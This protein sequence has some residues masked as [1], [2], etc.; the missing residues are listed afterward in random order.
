MPA[1]GPEQV[2]QV[3]PH[4]QPERVQPKRVQIVGPERVDEVV[5][6]L[7]AG[8]VVAIPTDTVYGLAALADDAAAVAALAARKGRAQQ[9]PIAVLFDEIEAIA[10]FVEDAASLRALARFW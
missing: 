9:Q 10:P 7:R 2:E 4:E 3:P 8:E 1:V 6:A 5:R